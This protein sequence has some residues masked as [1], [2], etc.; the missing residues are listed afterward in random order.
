M[1]TYPL[2]ST[3]WQLFSEQAAKTPDAIA[4]E[5]EGENLSFAALKAQAEAF[6]TSLTIGGIQQGDFVAV[7]VERSFAFAVSVLGIL[8]AKA[9]YVVI[10]PDFPI[11]RISQ[12]LNDSQAALLISQ[13]HFLS[14]LPA[15]T[16]PTWII[17]QTP[18]LNVPLA[19]NRTPLYTEQ[20]ACLF[21]TSGSTGR[22]KGVL[23]PDSVIINRVF[24]L[25]EAYP[26]ERDEVCCQRAAGN[27]VASL[28]ELF[29]PL[30]SGVKCVIL[31][32]E[33]LRDPDVLIAQLQG[34]NVSRIAVPPS[35][36][37]EML[38]RGANESTLPKLKF[39]ESIAEANKPPT[40][41]AFVAA[42]PNA[43]LLNCYGLTEAPFLITHEVRADQPDF[44]RS[45]IGRPISNAHTYVL[46]DQKKPVASG[47]VGELHLAG[48][49]AL[50]YFNNPEL[51]AKSFIDNPFVSDGT[52]LFNTGDLVRYREDGALEYQGRADDQIKINGYKIT[53]A[54]IIAVLSQ[55]PGMKN[56]AVIVREDVPDQKRLV[57][58]LVHQEGVLNGDDAGDYISA[59]RETLVRQLPSYMIPTAF[60]LMERLPLTFSG[61]LNRQAL[62]LPDTYYRSEKNA[63]LAP[64]TP[65]EISIA[66]LWSSLLGIKE[67][68]LNDDFFLLGG[69]SLLATRLSSTLKQQLNIDVPI[70]AI[71]EHSTLGNLSTYAESLDQVA[72]N[73]RELV[74]L[75]HEGPTHLSFAQQSL[76]VVD[77]LLPEAEKSLYNIQGLYQ[78]RGHLKIPALEQAFQAIV[79]RHEALRTCFISEDGV[80]QQVVLEKGEFALTCID[81]SALVDDVR[82][83]ALEQCIQAE[84]TK[85][86]DLTKAP[87]IRATLVQLTADE[88][89]LFVS[90]HHIVTDGWSKGILLTEI[91][92]FYNHFT[93]NTPLK[94]APLTV[95]YRDYSAWQQE[96]LQPDS[97]LFTDSL[98]YWR[99]KLG[100][101]PEPLVLPSYQIK[102]SGSKKG[103]THVLNLPH[104]LTTAVKQLAE[105]HRATPFMVLLASLQ[106]LLY[107][108][109]GQETIIVG[110]AI[111]GRQQAALEAM[112]GFFVNMLPLQADCSG[113]PKFSEFLNQVRGSTLDAYQH[114]ALPF[115]TLVEQL[116]ANGNSQPI[117]QVAFVLQNNQSA[118]LQLTGLETAEQ[119][120]PN[121]MSKFDLTF[122]ATEQPDGMKI[123]IEYAS[124]LFTHCQIERLSAHF[125][126]VL[127]QVSQNPDV[128]IAQ[129]PLLTPNEQQLIL[130]DWNQ[131][132]AG[133]PFDKTLVQLF[134]EQVARTPDNTALVLGDQS[135]SYQEFN[136]EINQ[137]A[138]HLRILGVKPDSLV[139]ISI[140]RSFA[141]M[142]TIFAIM[143]A[144]G[145]YVPLDPNYPQDRLDFILEDTQA[146]LLI[147]HSTLK[148]RFSHSQVILIDQVDVSSQ[149]S[150]NPAR[151]NSVDDLAY[152]IYTS[153]S[154]GVPKGVM[155][156]HRGVSNLAFA[157]C[158][159]FQQDSSDRVL[160][161]ASINFDAS[162][163][164]WATTLLI[165]ATLILVTCKEQLLGE[166]LINTIQQYEISIA[167]I[168]PSVL[169]S[170]SPRDVPHLKTVVVAG[171]ATPEAVLQ[172][173]SADCIVINAYGPTETSVCATM[174]V[175]QLNQPANNIGRPVD[176]FQLYILDSHL[177]PV[178]VGVAGE[179]YIGGI[180]LARGYLNRS[181]LTRERFIANP[182]ASEADRA[183]GYGRLYKTGD[184]VR[185]LAAGDVEY[186][187][188]N[189]SQVK[190]RGFRIELGE[191]ENALN[192][193]SLV[194]NSVVIIKEIS[195]GDKRLVAYIVLHT[196]TEDP[197]VL[198]TLRG[199]LKQQLPSHMV[200]AHFL[201]IKAIP[202]SPNKK[203]DRKA[204]EKFD[205]PLTKV[206]APTFIIA[207]PAEQ[208]L[209]L[210][211]QKVLKS[212]DITLDNNFFDVGG[213]S[214]L[215]VQVFAQL[216]SLWKEHSSLTSVFQ[217][218]TIKSFVQ[219]VDGQ[220]PAIAPTVPEKPIQQTD[221]DI[222]IVGMACRLPDADNIDQ[223]WRNLQ[224]GRESLRHF[225]RAELVR[226]GVPEHE[227]DDPHYVPTRGM[228]SH[229]TDFDAAFFGINA[230]EAQLIDPQQRLF[231]ETA[232]EALEHA[233][234][235]PSTYDGDIGL[236][237]GAGRNKY[238]SHHLLPNR[239]LVA[240]LGEFSLNVANDSGT[241]VTRVA[242]KFNLTGP[243]VAVQTACSTSLVAVHQA[244]MSL[245]L[246]ESSMV[247]AGGVSLNNLDPT[248]Y[249]Y[250]PGMILSPDGH[251]RAFDADSSG[252]VISQG[253]G[254]VVL[255]R[256]K[257]AL[258]DGDTVYGVIKGS[259]INNDGALKVGFTA[260]NAASQ[261]KVI[262][263][264]LKLAGV[265]P[266]SVHYVETHGTGTALG[267]PIEWEGLS[268]V[269]ATPTRGDNALIL[270][271]LKTNIGHTDA[272][273]GVA[274]LIKATLVL[275]HRQ[276]PATL[277]F[278][279][280]NPRLS[281]VN[282]PFYI[283]TTLV[284]LSAA[285]MVLR[286][287]VSS[288]GV[289]GTNAHVVL[290]QAPQQVSGQSVS[291]WQLL[292]LSARSSKAL[293]E[294]RERL[295][296]YLH[297]HPDS[298]LADVAYT[299]HVGRKTHA[300]RQAWVVGDVVQALDV[301]STPVSVTIQ[302]ENRPVV[303]LFAG[304][305]VQY[306]DMARGL[307]EQEPSFKREVDA[308]LAILSQQNPD[309]FGADLSFATLMDE[310]SLRS[311]A[312]VQVAIFVV[313]YSMAKVLQQWGI[314]P[315]AMLGHSQGEYV[316]A[317]L[318]GVFSLEDA[319]KL[320]AFR[321]ALTATLAPGSMLSVQLAPGVLAPYL[322]QCPDVELAAIN[323]AALI[324]V[325]GPTEAIHRLQALLQHDA[326]KCQL[327]PIAF[328]AHSRAVDAISVVLRDFIVQYITLNA[329]RIP[330][331]STVTGQWID[332]VTADYWAAHL[333]QTVLFLAGMETL[334]SHA[335]LAKALLIEVGP[336]T[337]LNALVRQH[338]A[339]TAASTLLASMRHPKDPQADR[340]CLLNLLGQLSQAGRSVNWTAF[341]ADQGR[342]RIG[343][344]TYP[345]ERQRFWLEKP[346]V[347]ATCVEVGDVSMADTRE[348]K[349]DSE[350]PLPIDAV[351]HHVKRV[352]Q[353]FLSVPQLTLHDNF[354]ACGGNSLLAISVFS[355]LSKH[356]D[357]TLNPSLLY[358]Y[359]TLGALVAQIKAL[360]Q[361]PERLTKASPLVCLQAGTPGVLPLFLVHP[362][363]G[364]VAGY[365]DLVKCLN[366]DQP[367]Y[368][369]RSLS[370]DGV[371]APFS[372]INVMAHHYLEVLHEQF[373]PLICYQL[374]GASY[375][376][377]VVYEMAQQLR[378]LGK[379]L[380]PL[381]LIDAPCPGTAAMPDKLLSTAE[382]LEYLLGDELA[383]D[384]HDLQ[385]M[386]LEQQLSAIHRKA[387]Q[388]GK[389]HVVPA[390]VGK[391]LLDTWLIHAESMWSYP[392][393]GYAGDVIFFAQGE[394]T[395]R[396]SVKS[397]SAWRAQVRGHFEAHTVPGHHT[398]MY[399]ALNASNVARHLPPHLLESSKQESK[400]AASTLVYPSM[401]DPVVT[402]SSPPLDQHD[403]AQVKQLVADALTVKRAF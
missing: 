241:L 376:G 240:N 145:A 15:L 296:D 120:V 226:Y 282:T 105:Q 144:G 293:N 287:G 178:P 192:E 94:L 206:S 165:G 99:E 371:V 45:P 269:F 201:T 71:F 110:S 281:R 103:N 354:F 227:L 392:L 366:P 179:L 329:P 34:A 230:H 369:F 254:I 225:T 20:V 70:R 264:A 361:N 301:L 82:V 370:L 300:Y 56:V 16:T 151:V 333:R 364:E 203:T 353:Q 276:L 232:W 172:R 97:P 228:V 326:V 380:A 104:S 256:L 244:C 236:Y 317:C 290:E 183:R 147:T 30:L 53:P 18:V 139:A 39:W 221:N 157:Q 3:V 26:F 323:G 196:P 268:S 363:G 180:G 231:L 307:Y 92:Q 197:A 17:D 283:N 191:I 382:A 107:R 387:E 324:V 351:E 374:G 90:M 385:R 154:T 170:F 177:Q 66:A 198:N 67:I 50:G 98:R 275:Q 238:L 101:N 378:A 24:W 169:T 73:S 164:E 27:F 52:K 285:P 175:Y 320:I 65:L 174:S 248:G 271:A 9:A 403:C 249:L 85:P 95:N 267:D 14:R 194:E 222:A 298:N 143:K 388:L 115:V 76:W 362:V 38:H 135:L 288:F 309:T 193:H 235:D 306:K 279:E 117:F 163:S 60:V 148:H 330:Y 181:D 125:Q 239:E 250:Q 77:Q 173:W 49:I 42:F 214:L 130:K 211:W 121:Q 81:L 142:I 308:C 350:T 58:Y 245:R 266:D 291:S 262:Q 78:L 381:I 313:Q 136:L 219:H 292:S 379:S 149:P 47:E 31:S 54:E 41:E 212:T 35:L 89:Q 233:G 127:T 96:R 131:T 62:P 391:A 265:H 223:F 314:T 360:Q 150:T 36:L 343:L 358:E 280:F 51:T 106:V 7:C 224:Q 367:V 25:Q 311:A 118:S 195:P 185:Y 161:Y 137:L 102:K 299:L 184:L 69:N 160:Q 297:A 93:L 295:K 273:A 156:E 332:G 2:T 210:I 176:N 318:A 128:N 124:D 116:K 75:P 243:A 109:S 199:A 4:L 263:T 29:T 377:I 229:V 84:A 79:A 251:C 395:K 355:A 216:P 159:V 68:G 345:F 13:T 215:A 341:Y 204:L 213:S 322:E 386:T 19:H 132:E 189:D 278:R 234:Y 186:L 325:S 88:C 209:L 122:V 383:F 310:P 100:S 337:T 242:Y 129:I 141:M 187:G 207:S 111:A 166:G 237:A 188:R 402:L 162:V 43:T 146:S 304:Q 348:R 114:Q 253:M 64:S 247:L 1:P 133:L 375:G 119:S 74:A 59:V 112:I 123:T 331:V 393:E 389:S 338:P 12:I 220:V 46:D 344:P 327:L 11:E 335:D 372:E 400:A 346:Q 359:A 258:A 72:S 40:V 398:S 126:S 357:L 167:T 284:D 208:T 394:S 218:P 270:G 87:L 352:W 5:H 401:G 274:G 286:A 255:K 22:P 61:K 252:T 217:Y 349:M 10:N 315:Q 289:G 28:R 134:E 205:L 334:L 190:L 80:P 368:A 261:A 168:P 339:K 158:A 153:G 83:S 356:F 48:P 171:E 63:Y 21:Y 86:F 340:A 272:A 55:M 390:N 305:G 336:N 347:L 246:G 397:E 57:A 8:Q 321:S 342:M 23:I 328:A 202:L 396:Y 138:H 32:N 260:P 113:N 155:V 259:A 200:P 152:V 140:E 257:D 365:L 33:A 319:L 44:S 384:R 91:S 302:S 277:H 399:K 37:A 312:L 303:F 108:H 373:G 6:G 182:F 294:S 316:V